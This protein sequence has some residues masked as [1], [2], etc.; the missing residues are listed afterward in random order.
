[1]N[2]T[3]RDCCTTVSSFKTHKSTNI[4]IEIK[5]RQELRESFSQFFAFDELNAHILTQF[6]SFLVSEQRSLLILQNVL[7]LNKR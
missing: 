4:E 5:I 6:T 7:A 1:M 2:P 3:R